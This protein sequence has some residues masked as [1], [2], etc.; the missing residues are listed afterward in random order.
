MLRGWAPP[1]LLETYHLERHAAALEN[2]EVTA[3]TMEFLVPRGERARAR[4]VA[5]LER[6]AAD[7]AAAGAVDSGRFAEPFWYTGSPL[8]TPEPTRPPPSRRPPRGVPPEPA[9]GVIVPDLPLDGG[10][11]L[12]RLLRGGFTLLAAPDLD[13]DARAAL[14]A[15]AR[16]ASPAPVDA[17]PD[18]DG[19]I[20]AGLGIRPGE[21]WLVRPDAHLAAI[22]PRPRAGALAAALRRAL[23]ADLSPG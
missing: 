6:A 8:T 18:P 3:A 4:R 5:A 23:G 16:T 7:P 9:P 1:D 2:L 17:V 15:E 19:A 21:V 20:A 13:T 10:T 11:R 22:L 12:R 14:T